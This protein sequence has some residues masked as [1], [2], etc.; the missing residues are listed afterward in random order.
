MTLKT[1][2]TWLKKFLSFGILIIG[3]WMHR[4]MDI[5]IFI[6]TKTFHAISWETKLDGFLEHLIEMR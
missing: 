6:L 3:V 1:I 5:L 4:L 2:F